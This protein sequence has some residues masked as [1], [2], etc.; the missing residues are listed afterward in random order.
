MF[1]KFNIDRKRA[2]IS[3]EYRKESLEQVWLGLPGFSYCTCIEG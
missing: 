2:G 3:Q 1:R